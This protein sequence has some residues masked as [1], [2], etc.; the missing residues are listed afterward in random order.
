M[1]ESKS[2]KR[3]DLLNGK[4]AGALRLAEKV[5]DRPIHYLAPEYP[6]ELG[7]AILY[8]KRNNMLTDEVLLRMK[9][10]YLNLCKG[11]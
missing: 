7:A 3:I 1:E 6:P 9:K 8:F 5:K 4:I 10:T 2:N 11:E